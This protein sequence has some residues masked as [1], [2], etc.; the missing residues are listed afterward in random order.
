MRRQIFKKYQAAIPDMGGKTFVTFEAVAGDDTYMVTVRKLDRW[1]VWA[2]DGEHEAQV[3]VN[4]AQVYVGDNLLAIEGNSEDIATCKLDVFAPSG[5]EPK[6]GQFVSMPAAIWAVAPGETVHFRNPGYFLRSEQ[7]KACVG[8]NKA[9][10]QTPIAF[11]YTNNGRLVEFLTPVYDDTDRYLE[12]LGGGNAGLKQSAVD[13]GIEYLGIP[14]T[15]TSV[16][17]TAFSPCTT[18]K[19]VALPESTFTLNVANTEVNHIKHISFGKQC[20]VA[21][22]NGSGFFMKGLESLWSQ[23]DA[24]FEARSSNGTCLVR[25]SDGA[26]ALSA[27]ESTGS[28]RI[29]TVPYGKLLDG[30]ICNGDYKNNVQYIGEYGFYNFDCHGNIHLAITNSEEPNVLAHSFEGTKAETVEISGH[31]GTYAIKNCRIEKLIVDC[32]RL[33]PAAICSSDGASYPFELD[34]KAGV[35]VSDYIGNHTRAAVSNL[36]CRDSLTFSYEGPDFVDGAN[37]SPY[38]YKCTAPQIRIKDMPTIYANSFEYLGWWDPIDSDVETLPVEDF[39]LSFLNS[40]NGAG[41]VDSLGF[42]SHIRATSVHMEECSTLE[43]IE[44]RAF[45]GITQVYGTQGGARGFFLPRWANGTQPGVAGNGIFNAGYNS[46]FKTGPFFIDHPKTPEGIME[47][48]MGF[49]AE[50]LSDGELLQKCN[51]SIM[52]ATLSLSELAIRLFGEDNGM[53]KRCKILDKDGL[54]IWEYNA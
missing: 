19:E 25:V 27:K 54:L 30:V 10:G 31:I 9:V 17:S 5:I 34:V 4:G 53:Y 7:T 26:L 20:T 1:R 24:L 46:L 13:D 18:L 14:E 52:G 6:S 44:Y 15:Y 38:V 21:Y 47:L 16:T 8:W 43:K 45:A 3:P 11:P 40:P 51:Q 35:Y 23:E 37:Y 39:T 50:G 12:D 41:K 42:S 32:D 49:S 36:K 33:E 29:R 48:R 2:S 22:P 28:E